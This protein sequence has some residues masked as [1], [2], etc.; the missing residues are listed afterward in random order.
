MPIW[1]QIKLQ[2]F[3]LTDCQD[4]PLQ[5]LCLKTTYHT[6]LERNTREPDRNTWTYNVHEIVSQSIFMIFNDDLLAMM[7][8]YPV[9]T[10]STKPE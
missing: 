8:L 4:L 2:I 10:L 9:Y 7:V 6:R 3:Q 1:Q 5:E